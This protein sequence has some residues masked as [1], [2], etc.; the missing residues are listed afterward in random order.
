MDLA[1]VG[2]AVYLAL[3]SK[4]QICQDVKIGLGAVGPIPTRAK[5][6]EAFLQG[7]V[8]SDELIEKVALKASDE[9]RPIDD[10][11]S[12]AEYRREM[13]IALTRRAL[14]QSLEQLE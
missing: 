5:K 14:K 8:V 1:I 10:I 13:I 12:S 11:R 7:K 9:A 2:V 4:K 6:A 3:D